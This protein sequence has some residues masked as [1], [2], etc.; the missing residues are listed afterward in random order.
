MPNVI[1]VNDINFDSEVKRSTL[2]VLVDF[3]APWCGHCRN[4]MPIIEDLAKE[5]SGKALIVKLNVDEAPIKSEEYDIRG[6]PALLI[7]K[8]GKLVEHLSGFHEKQKLKAAIE[9]YK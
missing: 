9:K 5:M 8:D 7:F 3:W 6:I 1:E 2:P 4:Q